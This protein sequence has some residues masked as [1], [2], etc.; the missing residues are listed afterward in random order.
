[1]RAAS[2]TKWA[3][4]ASQGCHGCRPEYPAFLAMLASGKRQR[5][6]TVVLTLKN[7]LQ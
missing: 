3:A 1:M 4:G 5:T 2:A 7:E 6:Y